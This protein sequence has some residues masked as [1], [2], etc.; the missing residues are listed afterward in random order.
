MLMKTKFEISVWNSIEEEPSRLD[1]S[2][3]G[4]RRFSRFEHT[5]IIEDASCFYQETK[6]HR[7]MTTLVG[8]LRS[9]SLFT[10]LSELEKKRAYSKLSTFVRCMGWSLD[11]LQDSV[12]IDDFIDDSIVLRFPRNRDIK[13]NLY[14]DEDSQDPNSPEEC[15]LSYYQKGKRRV[16]YDNIS[17]IVERLKQLLR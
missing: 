12:S 2:E 10:Q 5:E 14:F 3:Y 9:D 6:M 1:T 13:L 16:E 7:D 4:L 8:N 11:V 17:T 15:F